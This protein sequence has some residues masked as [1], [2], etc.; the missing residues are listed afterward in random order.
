MRLKNTCCHKPLGQCLLLHFYTTADFQSKKWSSFSQVIQYATL[1]VCCSSSILPQGR[2]LL[3]GTRLFLWCGVWLCE[4]SFPCS[5]ESYLFILQLRSLAIFAVSIAQSS[6][7]L[8]LEY[9]T[10]C[11]RGSLIVYVCIIGASLLW[12]LD[13]PQFQKLCFR[14]LLIA[15]PQEQVLCHR[16]Q[17]PFCWVV[18]QSSLCSVDACVSV[19]GL[20][21]Y[22]QPGDKYIHCGCNRYS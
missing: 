17:K 8:L 21:E 3:C 13:C 15:I 20:Y 9:T 22:A 6:L 1:S 10:V 14:N 19:M 4:T 5:G 16:W 11:F 18:V 2:H 7:C 12:Q